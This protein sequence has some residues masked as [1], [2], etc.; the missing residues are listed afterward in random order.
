[1]ARCHSLNEDTAR[2]S[3]GPLA[4]SRDDGAPNSATVIDL[5]LVPVIVLALK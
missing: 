5:V 2:R 1:M 4:S 3:S